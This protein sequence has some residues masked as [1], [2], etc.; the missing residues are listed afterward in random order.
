VC[1]PPA[2]TG[3]VRRAGEPLWSRPSFPSSW[4]IWLTEHPSSDGAC[5]PH[6]LLQN[7]MS[8]VPTSFFEQWGDAIIWG[9]PIRTGTVPVFPGRFGTFRDVSGQYGTRGSRW[10]PS[11][12]RGF[13][14]SFSD[15]RRSRVRG[16]A[17]V[18]IPSGTPY[19]AWIFWLETGTPRR[20]FR[21]SWSRTGPRS[22]PRPPSLGSARSASWWSVPAARK[23][24]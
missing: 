9:R 12:V 13:R 20:R 8:S 19:P 22:P 24:P 11:V 23:R 3:W 21:F 18:Q 2:D 16:W 17:R 6:R 10:L 5:Q 15:L 4:S 14:W 7:W 1:S